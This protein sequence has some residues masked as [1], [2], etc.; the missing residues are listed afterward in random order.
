MILDGYEPKEVFRHFEKIS[1]IPRASGNELAVSS[2]IA[3]Y[4]RGLGLEAIQDEWNNLTIFKPASPGY[5]G[6]EP[7]ILQGHLDMVAEKNADT[8]H[9]FSKDPIKLYIDG[10]YVKAYGTTLGADNG[11]GVAMCIALLESDIPHP[12]LEIILT[13]DEETGM[14]GAEN[15]DTSRLKGRRL[16]NLDSGREAAFTMGCAAGTTAEFTVPVRW[17]ETA[18]DSTVCTLMVKGL[19]GGHSGEDI[20]KERGNANRILGFLLAALD[21]SLKGLRL[22]KVEGGMKINAIP[23]ESKAVFALSPDE[24]ASV[25]SILE[26]CKKDLLE[27]Y[28]VPDPDL[29]IEWAFGNDSELKVMEA[30][31]GRKVISSLVLIPTGVE[32]MSMEIEGLVNSSCNLGV[33][34]TLED[35]VKISA[36]ARG[37]ADIFIRQTEKQIELLAGLIGAEIIFIQRS[38]AWPFN[39]DSPLLKSASMVYPLAF[40]R[41]AKVAAIHAGLECGIFAQKIPGLDII[42]FGPQVNECHTPYERLSISSTSRVWKFVQELLKVL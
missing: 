13:V 14:S 24:K 30:E 31:S 11:I 33:I 12:P 5:E 32:S 8:V 20:K 41:E 23:R 38:P 7:V 35:S 21:N 27:Q 17:T 36:M 37:A 18:D 29:C 40:D 25:E 10:D 3:Q 16:I 15:L 39:P 28:R 6:K 1:E 26:K 34:E 4:A 42:A 19:K 2:Y 9:D 22:S